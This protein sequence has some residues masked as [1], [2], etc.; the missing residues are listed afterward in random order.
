MA[1]RTHVGFC[2][3]LSQNFKMKRFLQ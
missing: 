2:V 1:T 3:S